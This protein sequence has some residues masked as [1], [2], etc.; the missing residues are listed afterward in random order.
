M[1]NGLNLGF[2]IVERDK[3]KVRF[4]YFTDEDISQLAF[5]ERLAQTEQNLWALL[6]LNTNKQL[7]AL[8]DPAGTVK[9]SAIINAVDGISALLGT[10][11]RV[12]TRIALGAWKEADTKAL[13]DAISFNDQGAENR[14][15]NLHQILVE[16]YTGTTLLAFNRQQN[17]LLAPIAAKSPKLLPSRMIKILFLGA[18]SSNSPLEL[19]QEVRRIQTNLKLA[20]ERDNLELKQEWAVTVETLMQAMLD[21]SPTIV[22]FSGHGSKSGIILLDEMGEPKAVPTKALSSLFQLFKDTVRCV[23][24]NSCYSEH[25][26]RVIRQHIPYVIGMRSSILDSAAVALSTG[27]YKALGAGKDIPF[28]FNMGKISIQMEGVSGGNLLV[29]L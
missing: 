18:N 17:E 20:R 19:D 10:F 1:S 29:L 23:V 14:A 11:F 21:E 4:F 12:G 22:H 24:L 9:E 6:S 15:L 13:L 26:A 28:A 8:E 25:Q 27:F 16:K 3:T 2:E 5:L 7:L